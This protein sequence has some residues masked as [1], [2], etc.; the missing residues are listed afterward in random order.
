MPDKS[1]MKCEYSRL[2]IPNQMEYARIA[3]IYAGEV[4]RKI[5]FDQTASHE[6]S[7]GLEDAIKISLRYSFEQHEQSEIEISFERTAEGLKISIHD[8][9]LPTDP[10]KIDY[11]PLCELVQ[12]VDDNDEH[13]L[14]ISSFMDTMEFRNLGTKG[15]QTVLIKKNR[16]GE[17]AE[18]AETCQTAVQDENS[19][20]VQPR[21]LS[22]I[23]FR[24]MREN[25]AIEVARAIYRTYGYSY[26]YEQVYFPAKLTELN[27]N[28]QIMT[29]VAV[30][31]S[32]TVVGTL[33]I[34][35][36]DENCDVA[37]IGQGVVIP[38]YRKSGVFSKL[39]DFQ[40]DQAIRSGLKGFFALAVTN[41]TFSQQTASR[42][43]GRDCA[44]MLNYIP[45]SV[46]FRG[47]D[48][49]WSGRI[50]VVV[51]Y[52]ELET[53]SP[54]RIF[55]PEKHLSFIMEIYRN[56][57]REAILGSTDELAPSSLCPEPQSHLKVIPALKYARITVTSYGNDFMNYLRKTVRE[58]LLHEVEIINLFLNLSDPDTAILSFHIEKL[59]F[60][61]GGILPRA[62]TGNDVLI[63]Q[64]LKGAPIN[65][66]EIKVASAFGR[67]IVEYVKQHDP[68]WQ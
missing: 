5:G 7:Q 4:A 9:G 10:A 17:T 19:R 23:T 36:W 53:C 26:G 34:M 27:R 49:S 3:A 2:I 12:E 25:E 37:E 46:D 39:V 41:H 6:I 63:L 20:S 32:Q 56:L 18:F 55:P 15:K 52:R 29:A 31:H 50:S 38:S 11:G 43:D 8:K 64:Y 35:K 13:L 47:F 45:A 59:G 57:D 61:F 44:I 30:D 40:I 62:A 1:E 54:Q 67:N 14:C 28:D 58:L 48:K 60:F 51:H 22:D 24:R 21:P 42:F 65:Y 33:S 16:S 68:N 66:D